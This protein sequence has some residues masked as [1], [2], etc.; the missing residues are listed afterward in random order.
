MGEEEDEDRSQKE[1]DGRHKR[2]DEDEGQTVWGLRECPS[3]IREWKA[4]GSPH[5]HTHGAKGNG[6]Y[7]EPYWLTL[8]DVNLKSVG[9]MNLRGKS[10]LSFSSL[11][12]SLSLF[13]FCNQ[14]QLRCRVRVVTAV[15]PLVWLFTKERGISS[16]RAD[17]YVLFRCFFKVFVSKCLLR[18][19]SLRFSFCLHQP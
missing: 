19:D 11:F 9:V 5:Y 2:S 4:K 13:L 16:V 12:F 14:L 18:S 7:L 10:I 3:V 6:E 1:K 17:A 8:D 15:E